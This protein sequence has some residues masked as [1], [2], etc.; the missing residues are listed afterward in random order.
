MPARRRSKRRLSG[1]VA[2]V[3]GA[4]R[5]IG[6]AVARA[7]AS[8]GC[9]LVLAG[10]T[11][12]ALEKAARKLAHHK[13]H[14]LAKICDVRDPH[15]VRALA[16]S[17]KKQ[18]PRV[19]ILVN[20]A[21]VA[22]P[23]LPVA[24]LPYHVWKSVIDTNLT[25]TFLVTREILPLMR[26][27]STIVNNLSIAATRVFAGSSAYNASKHGALGLTNTLREELRSKG[28]RVIA[29][30]PGA[31]DTEIWDTLWP[32]APRKKMLS[33]DTI[34]E[35]LTGAL[36]LPDNSTVEELTILPTSGAL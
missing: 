22:H 17:I 12:S 26:R 20:N 6:L 21:G 9:H 10:R 8:E 27:G 35:A 13:V 11:L 36:L 16:A 3:T 2:L 32:K 29:L 4:S 5:G 28:I 23:N 31:T 18:F 1:K 7:L 33:A 30:L 14:V 24:T 34:A 25:G 15:A 19:D